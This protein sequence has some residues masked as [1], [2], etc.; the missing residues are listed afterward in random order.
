MSTIFRILFAISIT[1]SPAIVASIQFVETNS[2][3]EGELG[4]ACA[5]TLVNQRLS[6][7]FTLSVITGLLGLCTTVLFRPK[8]VQED[9]RASI[10]D[11]I[12][13]QLLD[14]DRNSARI[15]LF[16]DVG[17]GRRV[18]YKFKD[19]GSLVL[20]Q[21]KSI[22][23]TLGYCYRGDYIQI[24]YR[25]GNHCPNSKTYL[26]VNLE[27]ADQCQGIAGQV[28][29]K[30]IEMEKELP[31]LDGIDLNEVDESHPVVAEVLREG[32][33]PNMRILRS[34]KKVAPYY[35][36][37]IIYAQGGKKKIVLMIDSWAAENPFKRPDTLKTLAIYRKQLSASFGSVKS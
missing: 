31:R 5:K 34:I 13:E 3:G 6:L 4:V 15:T 36:G 7:S 27:R 20:K 30:E 37:H 9:F 8:S 16:K 32:Y 28:R 11:G 33:I 10:A 1:V 14:N 21:R 23:E 18:W 17:F 24:S 22:V 29:Q 19:F 12:F 25:W 2:F 35:Y 26:Y